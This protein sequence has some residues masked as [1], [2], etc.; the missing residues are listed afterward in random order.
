MKVHDKGKPDIQQNTPNGVPFKE[1]LHVWIKVALYSFG[2]PAGQ[3][4]VMH[5]FLVEEKKW[6]SENRFLHAL[7]YCMLLPGPEAQQ[8]AIYIGWLLHKVKGGL[9]AGTLFVLPG[10]VSILLLSLLYAGFNETTIVQALF[11]GIKP[12]VMAIVIQ[13][14]F[15]IG[16]RALKNNVMIM[17]SVMAFI[18]IFF[19]NIPF[20]IIVLGAGLIGYVGGKIWEDQFY[21]VKGHE[22]VD[23]NEGAQTGNLNHTTRQASKSKPSWKKSLKVAAIWLTLWILPLAILA[24]VLGFDHIFVAEG[25]FF[26][27]T[28]A[29]TFG[30]AYSVLAYIAQKAVE[31]YQWLQP[32]EMLDGLGMAE[33]TPGPLI[34]VVQFVGFMGAYRNPGMMDPMMAGVIASVVVTWVTFVPCFLFIFLGAPYIEYLRGNK[35]LTTTLSGITAAVVGVILNL[36]IWF[37]IH[38]VFSAVHSWEGYGIKLDIPVLASADIYALFIGIASFIAL[39]IYKID[40]LKVLAASVIV[41]ILCYY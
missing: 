21:V 13:A 12:A 30:G 39:F 16:K 9:V 18:A 8:L 35:T 38:T 25:L 24:A 17:L 15:K 28:A 1:A 27:K 20:P 14:V 3:I 36:G 37:T 7:N 23:E 41:G 33:T 10:F 6:V 22:V 32:G 19:L 5:K 31:S 4:A 40:M 29:V 34:Q 2:G 11:Y 26:S